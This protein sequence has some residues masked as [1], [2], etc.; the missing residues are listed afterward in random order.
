MFFKKKSCFEE[1]KDLWKLFHFSVW[2]L[3]FI[4]M[5]C[6]VTGLILREREKKSQNKKAGKEIFF[7]PSSDECHFKHTPYY[8][9]PLEQSL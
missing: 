3:F 7:S 2:I 4:L 5:S 9:S 1:E 6:L 8:V